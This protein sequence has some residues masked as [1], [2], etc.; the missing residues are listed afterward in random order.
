MYATY[1]RNLRHITLLLRI[2]LSTFHRR[3]PPPSLLNS[4]HYSHFLRAFFPWQATMFPTHL[5]QNKCRTKLNANVKNL[6][7]RYRDIS[8]ECTLS[9]ILHTWH[10]CTKESRCRIRRKCLC[11]NALCGMRAHTFFFLGDCFPT[12]KYNV[13]AWISNPSPHFPPRHSSHTQL[14]IFY[15]ESHRRFLEFQFVLNVL[16]RGVLPAH[17]NPPFPPLRFLSLPSRN[18]LRNYNNYTALS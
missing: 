11:N 10:V 18:V 15:P 8:L 1:N 16:S 13:E 3:R 9:E 7:K 17:S 5:Q 14:C 6:T 12:A 2:F 4:D